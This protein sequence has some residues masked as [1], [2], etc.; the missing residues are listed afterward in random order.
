MKC[1][2]RNEYHGVAEVRRDGTA[3]GLD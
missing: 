1:Q 2:T 3:A